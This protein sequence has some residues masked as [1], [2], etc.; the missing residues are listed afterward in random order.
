M[1]KVLTISFILLL[2]GCSTGIGRA[3]NVAIHGTP[4]EVK[5]AIVLA[6]RNTKDILRQHYASV[7]AA[8][9]T[10]DGQVVQEWAESRFREMEAI[11]AQ[12][13]LTDKLFIALA[14]YNGVEIDEEYDSSVKEADERRRAFWKAITS[15][16]KEIVNDIK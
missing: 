8:N 13:E 9:V 2:V 5:Q 14:D 1:K 11:N 10:K 15:S 6:N 4:P 12:I 7:E 16:A 3:F